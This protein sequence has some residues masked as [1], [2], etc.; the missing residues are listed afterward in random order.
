MGGQ[1]NQVSKCMARYQN[2]VAEEFH[3][4][5]SVSGW[6]WEAATIHLDMV[7]GRVILDF[8][9]VGYL[10][11]DISGDMGRRGWGVGKP[12]KRG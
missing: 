8:G 6:G 3:A 9:L 10:M 1:N 4:G 12:L 11:P 5:R 7:E 2:G